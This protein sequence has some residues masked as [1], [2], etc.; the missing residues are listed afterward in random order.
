MSE[1]QEVLRIIAKDA[2]LESAD[3]VV[4]QCAADELDQL[5]RALI[6]TNTALIESQQ[7]QIATNEQLIEAR[8]A[9]PKPNTPIWVTLWSGRIALTGWPIA[10][11]P[12]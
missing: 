3:R 11:P 8:R 4:I 12:K 5:Q 7:R 9:A 2:R 6:V 10:E 1:T